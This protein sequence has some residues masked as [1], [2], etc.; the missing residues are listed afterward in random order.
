[1]KRRFVLNVANGTIDMCPHCD[2]AGIKLDDDDC[3]LCRHPI[4]VYKDENENQ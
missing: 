1:M 2:F 4:I 3:P